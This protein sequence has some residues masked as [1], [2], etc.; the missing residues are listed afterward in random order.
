MSQV[1]ANAGRVIDFPLEDIPPIDE[2]GTLV[3]APVEDAWAALLVVAD[4]S[5]SGRMAER[6][7]RVLA[8]SHTE[9]EGEI[10]RIGS[11]RP[12]F[13]VTRVIEPAVLALEGQHRFS[14]YGLIFRLEPT[15]DERTLL[16]AETRAQFPG[17]KGRIY[18][19]VVIGT[20]LHV[21]AVNRMLR[22]VRRRAER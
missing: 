20:R 6:V 11:T 14:R 10:D 3:L 4:R 15:R 7:A 22:G 16:R 8:C 13:I 1:E 9:P 19:L 21:V 2:H 17:I 18:K 12:G 5:L